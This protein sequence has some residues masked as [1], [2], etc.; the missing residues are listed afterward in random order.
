MNRIRR[1]LCAFGLAAFVLAVAAAPAAA[2]GVQ[3]VMTSAN[4]SWRLSR[5]PDLTF[6]A[7]QPNGVPVVTV[8]DDIR[9]HPVFSIRSLQRLRVAW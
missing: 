5:L 9:Y 1:R 2:S 6:S 4:L 8:D 3:V 7:D